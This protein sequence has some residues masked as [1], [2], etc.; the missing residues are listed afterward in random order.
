M[1]PHM[2][3]AE[4]VSSGLPLRQIRE[5]VRSRQPDGLLDEQVADAVERAWRAGARWSEI[6]EALT[7]VHAPQYRSSLSWGEPA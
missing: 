1:T 3:A 4:R 5:L 2:S 6:S 7:P